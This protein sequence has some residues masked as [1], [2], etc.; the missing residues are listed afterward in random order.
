MK[1]VICK[2]GQT[3]SGLTTVTVERDKTTVIIKEVPADICENCGEYFLNEETVG[4]IEK[5]MN[6]AVQHGVEF[7]VL[8]Y[9]A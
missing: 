6:Q 7:E 8:R 1:C 2:Q 9:A 3:Q 5:L 4:N